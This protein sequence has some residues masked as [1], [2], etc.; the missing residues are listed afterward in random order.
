MKRDKPR[1][2][3][4]PFETQRTPHFYST[5]KMR[6]RALYLLSNT[7]RVISLLNVPRLQANHRKSIIILVSG[8]KDAKTNL[9]WPKFKIQRRSMLALS[10]KLKVRIPVRILKNLILPTT[11]NIEQDK[12]VF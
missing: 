5:Q 2:A 4:H 6:K 3:S 8:F 10:R 9:S 7:G 12:L 1:V 11:V